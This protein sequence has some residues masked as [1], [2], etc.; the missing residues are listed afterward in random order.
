MLVRDGG[1]LD[2]IPLTPVKTEKP[3]MLRPSVLPLFHTHL[4]R[5]YAEICYA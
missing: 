2:D 3:G 5:P 1:D 4:S